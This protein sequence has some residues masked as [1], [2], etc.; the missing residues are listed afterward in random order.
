M[1]HKGGTAALLRRVTLLAQ[2]TITHI[3]KTTEE[4]PQATWNIYHTRQLPID[5]PVTFSFEEEEKETKLFNFE[6]SA[7]ME[8]QAIVIQIIHNLV[9]VLEAILRSDN[10]IQ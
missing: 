3:H 7:Q 2:N 5:F 1:C 10:K 8:T 4:H 9:H 6:T